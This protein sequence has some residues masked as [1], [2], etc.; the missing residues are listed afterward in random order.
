M[1][2]P[3]AVFTSVVIKPVVIEPVVVISPVLEPFMFEPFMVKPSAVEIPS[4][5]PFE[6]RTI[7]FIIDPVTEVPVPYWVVVIRTPGKFIFIDY[8]CGLIPFLV[9][10][11]RRVSILVSR[12]L[13]N[14][15]GLI[16]DR[17]RRRSGINP[18]SGDPEPYM[19]V[20]I[21]L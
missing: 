1:V 8:R 20:E 17:R 21:Y 19:C 9:G 6:I 15:S 12:I 11:C 5:I 2:I 10:R 4:I 18:Y 16:N 3:S 7:V 14:G 13:V